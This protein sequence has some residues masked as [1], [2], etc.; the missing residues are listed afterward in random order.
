M[1]IGAGIQ[2]RVGSNGLSIWGIP[3]KRQLLKGPPWS[4]HTVLLQHN[5]PCSSTPHHI[6]LL[7]VCLVRPYPTMQYYI[8]FYST[9]LY[10][11]ICGSIFAIPY[12]SAMTHQ[13][14]PWHAI[15]C[16]STLHHITLLRRVCLG[17]PYHTR[18]YYTITYHDSI[19]LE[20]PCRSTQRYRSMQCVTTFYSTG[21]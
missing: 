2:S 3:A 11:S 14:I 16:S 13:T 7:R 17:Q 21:M 1:M 20:V 4:Y 6:T 10:S 15:P 9:V 8:I 12:S 19:W 5:I 18:Q